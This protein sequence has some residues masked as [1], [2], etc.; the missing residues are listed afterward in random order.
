MYASA[1]QQAL[2]GQYT[3]QGRAIFMWHCSRIEEFLITFYGMLD[4]TDAASLHLS[5]MRRFQ[6][7]WSGLF[8]NKTCLVCLMAQPEC[9]GPCGHSMCEDCIKRF[10]KRSSIWEDLYD[11]PSCM[12][13]G[14]AGW[15][16]RIK[17][18]TAGVNI[19]SIDGGGTRGI[20]PLRFLSLIQEKL[21]TACRLQDLFDL[22]LGTSSGKAY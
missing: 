20:V 16:S 12:L 3:E 15:S 13:C 1:C 11:L 18:L 21:G 4:H 6:H 17:P 10:G 22:V 14:A 7:W 2:I 8:S 9:A 19:L 5:N